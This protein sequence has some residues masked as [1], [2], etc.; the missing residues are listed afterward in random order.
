MEPGFSVFYFFLAAYQ[1]AI[2]AYQA[3]TKT[4]TTNKSRPGFTTQTGFI[5]SHN[6]LTYQAL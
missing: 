2:M 3:I 5:S 1:A 6:I 4:T